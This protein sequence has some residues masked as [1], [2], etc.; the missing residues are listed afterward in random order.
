MSRH[1]DLL[2]IGGGMVGSAM[3]CL[4]AVNDPELSIVV[5]EARE[6][7]RYEVGGPYGIR[8]SAIS[9]A[10]ARI[11]GFCGAWDSIASARISPYSEMRVWDASGSARGVGAVHFNC[12]EIGEPYLGHIVE[13]DLIQSALRQR[14][15]E[16]PSVRWLA[17]ASLQGME[18]E[19]E[20]AIVEL[21]DGRRLNAKL[22]IGADGA[23]S[24]SRK[25][26]GIDTGG[27]A[28]GQHALVT[29][30]VTREPHG[31]TARQRFLPSGPLAFLPLADGRCSI[32]WSTSPDEAA[33]LLELSDGE[34]LTA[35]GQASDHMLGEVLEC[36]QRAAFPLQM[37]FAREYTLPRF[38]LI[39]DA[40]HAV[41]PLAGQGV[42]MGF[43]DAASLAQ[44]ISD[45]VSKDRDPGDGAVLRRYERWR[46]G[47]NLAT[48]LGC[49][50]IGRL[51]SNDQDLLRN[52][53]R[54][55]LTLVNAAP[56]L[57]NQFIRRAMGLTGD[58]PEVARSM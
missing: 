49:D 31:E 58:L 51:F 36:G 26:A 28:Y 19:A 16:L 3:A 9:S 17:P 54:L 27:W 5:L 46:K 4:V 40:A 34:F 32:V 23:G 53:R 52:A 50:A 6:P 38:A 14:L 55:G 30:I 20:K 1:C 13:N 43:L 37:K 15:D 42:N 41:H 25:L 39:G 8:V 33:R 10:S 2:V 45:A 11:L 21:E 57:K 7:V 24:K 56:V 48:L 18:L 44:T 35:L 47:E 22:V 12:A 29:H